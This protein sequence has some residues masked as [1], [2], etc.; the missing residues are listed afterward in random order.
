MSNAI[1]IYT[2]NFKR[3]WHEVSVLKL[4]ANLTTALTAAA[5]DT[6]LVVIA[7]S[8]HSFLFQR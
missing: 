3:V 5:L 7:S 8:I 2:R 1:A 6:S 4:D